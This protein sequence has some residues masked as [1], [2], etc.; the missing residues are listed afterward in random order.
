MCGIN[1]IIYFCQQESDDTEKF[2]LDNFK[3]IEL[4]N[5]EIAH[6]GPDGDGKF[7]NF[8]VCFG[9]RR[10]SIID[11]SKEADQPMF[12]DDKSIVIIYNGEIYNYIELMSELISKGHKF[13][14][15]SDTEVII[16]SYQEFGTDCVKKFNGMWSFALYDFNKNIFFASRD[17]FGVKPFYYFKD[18]GKLIFSSEIKA[19]LK[20]EK[21]TEAN[22]QKVFEY[23]AYGYKTSNGDTF[24]N[25]INELRAAHNIVIQN[26]KLDI[27]KYWDFKNSDDKNYSEKNVEEEIDSLIRDSVK[28]RF[29][30]DV[31]VSIL[32]S[33]GLDSSIITKITDELIN[34]HKLNSENVTAYSAIFPG[35]KFD[36][37]EVIKEF[38][39]SC[40]H[41]NS[42]FLNPDQNNL[43][44]SVDEFVYAMGEP[45]F[46][47][48]SFAHFQLMKEIK[49]NNIKVVLNGQGADES[50]CGYGRYII[51]YFL[52]DKLFSDPVNL[53]SQINSISGKM[54][55]SYNFILMQTLKS[56]LSRKFASYLRSKYQEKVLDCLTNNF[57]EKNYP[58]FVNPDYNKFSSGNLSGFL[59][60]NINYQGF[61]QILHYEDHSAMSSSVEM[62]SPF[63]DY[64][65]M[66][67]AFSLPVKY[68]FDN[69]ITKKILR[70]IYKNKLPEAITE[71]HNKIGFKTPFENWMN[72]KP[73]TDYLNELLNSD[74]F[75]SKKIWKADKIRSIFKNKEQFPDF[76]F[77]R[78]IN[79]EL[80]SKAYGI[81]N[82]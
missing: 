41:I 21:I 46:S 75:N 27:K 50:W 59:K 30:S 67:L 79:L 54:N 80:W 55:Y 65:L 9:H 12:S 39:Q 63:I 76:P 74:S 33:G 15:K 7:I 69:G 56:I 19:I 26:G 8:P 3:K 28:L 11:L 10:L 70:E 35:Y 14:T 45:V 20:I 2:N 51:G 40:S 82:L 17:R 48:T 29:R 78:I 16:R 49:K 47:T 57:R 73:V 53:F 22:H 18:K 1:G 66:E 34:E 62:R 23:L 6:R 71:N 37:S 58:G 36:E 68:K 60:Y 44:E 42:V 81:N 61:N 25:G 38:L 43:L 52:L 5:S 24:F 13:R 72:Q 77:W 64:R 31:P 4:M 32:L